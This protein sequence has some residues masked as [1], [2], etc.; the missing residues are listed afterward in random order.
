MSGGRSRNFKAGDKMGPHHTILALVDKAPGRHPIFIVWDHQAWCPMACKF[1]RTPEKADREAAMLA[2]L[3]HPNIVRLFG[4]GEHANIFIEF[5]EGPTLAHML[6]RQPARGGG[7]SDALRLAIHV[8]AALEFVH[9]KGIVHL[10]LSPSNVIITT[11]GR[12]VLIDFGTARRIGEARPPKSVGTNSYMAPE[13]CRQEAEVGPAA[14]TFGLGM[15]L[16]ELLAGSLPFPKGTRRHPFPQLS[17]EP[18]SL[19]LHR[20]TLPKALDALIASCLS[21]DPGERPALPDLLVRF[22]DFIRTG[23]HMWPAGF[24]PAMAGDSAAG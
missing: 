22:H 23:P 13:E 10:D 7:I 20:P 16:F 21:P 3:P 18:E 24:Q 19:R 17:C 4:V 5:L 2:A 15:L 11:A 6:D 9:G 12:P 1:F 8:G 14:D